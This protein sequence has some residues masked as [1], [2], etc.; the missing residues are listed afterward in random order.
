MLEINVPGRDTYQI[1]NIVFDYN[2]TLATDGI[3]NDDIREAIIQLKELANVYVIT[4]DTHGNVKQQCSGL[5]VNITTFPTGD[6]ATYKKIIV[7]ELGADKTL[8][9]G[10]GY[11]DIEMFKSAILAIAIIGREGC[12]GKLIEVADIVVTSIEN[13][14]Q[15]ILKPKRAIATLRG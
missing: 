7:E 13:A 5:G 15:I 12:S 6:A 14:I 10:N 2:G 4:A 11:N 3:I 8:C 9:I 1:A